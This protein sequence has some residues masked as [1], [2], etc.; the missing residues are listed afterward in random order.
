MSFIL[1]TALKRVSLNWETETKP[2]NV[3]HDL[4]CPHKPIFVST[5]QSERINYFKVSQVR[6]GGGRAKL[7]YYQHIFFILTS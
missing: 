2:N 1:Q 3:C 6:C 4:I 5:G 7:N